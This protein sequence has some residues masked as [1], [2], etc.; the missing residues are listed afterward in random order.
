MREEQERQVDYFFDGPLFAENV[1]MVRYS[2]VGSSFR[3]EKIMEIKSTNFERLKI[4]KRDYY[5]IEPKV[6]QT[7]LKELAEQIN[8]MTEY[9]KGGLTE[10]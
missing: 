9:F 4:L 5:L 10:R 2:Y 8:L 1:D 7:S 6:A 3:I